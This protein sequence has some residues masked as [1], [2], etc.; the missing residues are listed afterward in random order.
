MVKRGP[1]TDAIARD[2][3][4]VTLL[5]QIALRTRRSPSAPNPYGLQVGQAMIG[6]Q[7]SGMSEKEYRAAKTRLEGQGLAGFRGTR[8][9]TVAWLTGNRVFDLNLPESTEIP[10]ANLSENGAD[11]RADL[12]ADCGADRTCDVNPSGSG[13]YSESAGSKGGRVGGDVCAKGATFQELYKNDSR[14]GAQEAFAGYP[15][16]PDFSDDRATFEALLAIWNGCPGKSHMCDTPRRQRAAWRVFRK[17]IDELCQPT[18]FNPNG[19]E[20]H[21]ARKCLYRAVL[22]YAAEWRRHP[23]PERDWALCTFLHDSE[24]AGPLWRYAEG[25]YSPEAFQFAATAPDRPRQKVEVPA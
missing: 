13:S 5:L 16:E 17:V 6:F 9:G 8:K 15:A 21:L 24:P 19:Y 2:P 14:K 7:G 25:Y 20:S 22:N 23:L 18:R 1:A 4:A 12:G 3:N 11:Q 10:G